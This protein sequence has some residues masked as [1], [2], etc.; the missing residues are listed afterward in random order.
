[1]LRAPK[2][3]GTYVLYVVVGDH[4]DRGEVAVAPAE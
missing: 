2:T 4:A 1:V 3:P